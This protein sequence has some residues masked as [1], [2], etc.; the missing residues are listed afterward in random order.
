MGSENGKKLLFSIDQFIILIAWLGAVFAILYLKA[1]EMMVPSIAAFVILNLAFGIWVNKTVKPTKNAAYKK[2]LAIQTIFLLVWCP[3]LWYLLFTSRLDLIPIWIIILI[4]VYIGIVMASFR[5]IVLNHNG[6]KPAE[7][8]EHKQQ[9]HKKSQPS[10]R[11]RK[12]K[13]T[14]KKK[15]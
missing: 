8:Q 4:L 6:Q 3:L 13:K 9:E 5:S 14:A 7:H 15:K 2:Y 12:V 10:K 11:S 1:Y